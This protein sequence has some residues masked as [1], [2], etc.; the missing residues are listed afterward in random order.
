[1]SLLLLSIL[2]LGDPHCQ[3]DTW[4]QVYN[5]IVHGQRWHFLGLGVHPDLG[6]VICEWQLEVRTPDPSKL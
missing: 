1:M 3:L 6:C 4:L 5:H 2:T